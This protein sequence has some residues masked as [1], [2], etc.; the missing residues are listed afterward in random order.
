MRNKITALVPIRVGS[1]RVKDKNFRP[2]ANTTLLKLKLKILTQVDTIDEIVVNTNS[3]EAI[4]IAK[5]YGVS[6]FRREEYYASSEC[7]NTEHWENLAET[8]D[9][10][11]IIHTPCTAPLVKVKTYYDFINRFNN[12]IDMGYDSCNSVSSVKEFLWLD[13]KPLN[14]DLD[15]VPN[16][17]DLPD[18]YNLTFGISI[19]GKDDMLKYKN[20]VGKKPHF[21]V[22]DE[23]ESVDI[24]NQIDFD[25]A[26]FLYSR[27]KNEI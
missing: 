1:Q 23:I 5:D 7:T 3:D 20:V 10:D 16:S 22:L 11:Y 17:Q 25:F 12:S 8:T 24:D 14:Y 19:I 21:Y 27:C 4:Q 26:E 9:T 18:I 2:F 6:Y 13:N 15:F